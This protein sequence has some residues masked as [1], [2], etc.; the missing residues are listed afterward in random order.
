MLI[1]YAIF[2]TYK[3]M[4]CDIAGA[5]QDQRSHIINQSIIQYQMYLNGTSHTNVELASA[6]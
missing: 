4:Q 2:E 1:K 5:S 6:S 3:S